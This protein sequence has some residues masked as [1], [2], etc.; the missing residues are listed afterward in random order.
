[1]IKFFT[2]S[3][4]LP[5]RSFSNT[6]PGGIKGKSI[7]PD[8]NSTDASVYDDENTEIKSYSKK[9]N[10]KFQVCFALK[11]YSDLKKN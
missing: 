7:E 1:M 2:L 3:A 10:K 11:S 8:T 4:D 5:T 9:K 6:L